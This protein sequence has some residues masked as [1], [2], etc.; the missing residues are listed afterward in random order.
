MAARP[1]GFH[2][3]TVTSTVMQIFSFHTGL[4]SIIDHQSFDFIQIE[5]QNSVSVILQEEKPCH[6]ELMR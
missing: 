4:L 1:I 2:Q 3:N 5:A 6:Y